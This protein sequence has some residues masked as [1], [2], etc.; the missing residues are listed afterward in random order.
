M[1]TNK[2]KQ[3]IEIFENS[4][5][6]TMELEANDIKLKLTKEQSVST[7][8][9][10]NNKDIENSIQET[11]LP[12]SQDKQIKAPLV[13]T[14]YESFAPG[15]KPFITEGQEIHKGDIV[16]IIEAMKVMNEIHSPYDGI[17]KKICLNNGELVEFDQTLILM[18]E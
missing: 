2:I 7:N 18:G 4:N 9:T 17:V 16:C 3:L 12:D 14:Y 5:V 13:G 10:A 1:D 8:V 6:S 11:I 15:S